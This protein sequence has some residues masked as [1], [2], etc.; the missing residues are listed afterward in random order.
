MTG[1]EEHHE[2]GEID[3]WVQ[4]L[5]AVRYRSRRL[6]KRILR[7]A[8]GRGDAAGLNEVLDLIRRHPLAAEIAAEAEA[9]EAAN[10]EAD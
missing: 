6:A 5:H 1:R 10:L 3:T 8:G 7:E 9:L 2:L 4:V